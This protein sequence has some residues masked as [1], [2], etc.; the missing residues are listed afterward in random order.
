ML[1]NAQFRPVLCDSR[2]ILDFVPAG[3]EGAESLKHSAKKCKDHSFTW[4]KKEAEEWYSKEVARRDAAKSAAEQYTQ[5]F[6][7]KKIIPCATCQ[8]VFTYRKSDVEAAKKIHAHSGQDQHHISF[9]R[10]WPMDALWAARAETPDEFKC[11]WC[12]KSTELKPGHEAKQIKFHVTG[13]CSWPNIFLGHNSAPPARG[14]LPEDEVEPLKSALV[15][16]L[17]QTGVS[18]YMM[19]PTCRT[20]RLHREFQKIQ[21]QAEDLKLTYTPFKPYNDAQLATARE[22]AVRFPEV[23]YKDPEGPLSPAIH[24]SE[25]DELW[26]APITTPKAPSTNTRPLFICRRPQVDIPLSNRF[27]PLSDTDAEAD[28][29]DA[30]KN[31]PNARS[32]RPKRKRDS[33]SPP[34]GSNK[35]KPAKEKPKEP[36][37][38]PPPRKDPLEKA[39]TP[40]ILQGTYGREQQGYIMDL[41]D[42]LQTKPK[43]KVELASILLSSYSSH[44]PTALREHKYG[45][46]PSSSGAIDSLTC[47]YKPRDKHGGDAGPTLLTETHLWFALGSLIKANIADPKSSYPRYQIVRLEDLREDTLENFLDV[48]RFVVVSQSA[49]SCAPSSTRAQLLADLQA[50]LRLKQSSAPFPHILLALT[51]DDSSPGASNI[52]IKSILNRMTE[53]Y[54]DAPPQTDFS[55][56]LSDLIQ[57]YQSPDYRR[58]KSP[59]AKSI[60]ELHRC[61]MEILENFQNFTDTHD[62]S[63]NNASAAADAA[64]AAAAAAAASS[65]PPVPSS[66]TSLSYRPL[67]PPPLRPA[68]PVTGLDGYLQDVAAAL[69]ETFDAVEK[70]ENR[71]KLD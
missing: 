26:S 34:Q 30:G 31:R 23:N 37:P 58:D 18:D 36:P 24:P 10:Y 5:L 13:A 53:L 51:R 25:S 16:F 28:D 4:S 62:R 69:P 12:L 19:E 50:D 14:R 63:E 41:C 39:S 20:H 66:G 71:L 55:E 38:P 2:R 54:Q 29:T 33:A 40:I 64:D 67:T 47:H 9:T 56:I 43:I 46:S 44:P 68:T 32:N 49:I 42:R 22:L 60:R 11:P 59:S 21:A 65:P 27:E 17:V 45:R 35:K 15:H 3:K 52:N 70:E 6:C 8:G 7:N 48:L 61:S 1:R 57:T